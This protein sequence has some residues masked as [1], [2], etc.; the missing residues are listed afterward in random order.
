MIALFLNEGVETVHPDPLEGVARLDQS[1]ALSMARLPPGT[2]EPRR[3]PLC[4][5]VAALA[6]DLHHRIVS[7]LLRLYS[8]CNYLHRNP[9]VFQIRFS[10]EYYSL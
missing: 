10:K 2:A 1:I 4:V 7:D 8:G 6:W 3:V 9:D 5:G